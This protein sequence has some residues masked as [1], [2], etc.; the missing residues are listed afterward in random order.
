MDIISTTQA[1]V[2]NNDP[3]TRHG[4]ILFHFQASV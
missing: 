1:L 3:Y 2:W 4:R